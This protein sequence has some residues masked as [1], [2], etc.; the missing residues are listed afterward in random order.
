LIAGEVSE[1][2]R[3]QAIKVIKK[4]SNRSI[5]PQIKYYVKTKCVKQQVVII[6]VSIKNF[7]KK[8]TER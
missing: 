5:S 6:Q 4:E 1:V 8:K 3:N 7:D 2:T